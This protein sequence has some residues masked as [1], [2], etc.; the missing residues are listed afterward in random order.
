MQCVAVRYGLSR[1]RKTVVEGKMKPSLLRNIVL[2]SR[3]PII[4]KIGRINRI[5]WVENFIATAKVL[6]F[7]YSSI[8]EC[9]ECWLFTTKTED[10]FGGSFIVSQPSKLGK[11]TGGK[12][13]PSYIYYLTVVW[14]QK[15]H[16]VFFVVSINKSHKQMLNCFLQMIFIDVTH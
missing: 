8:S 14:R 9:D 3:S 1:T 5:V 15:F 16:R 10:A 7:N 2:T 13:L 12:K 11:M 6:Y 4:Y